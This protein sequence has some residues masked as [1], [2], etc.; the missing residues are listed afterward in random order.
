MKPHHKPDRSAGGC[1]A[2]N[3]IFFLA[4]FEYVGMITSS[5]KPDQIWQSCPITRVKMKIKE[6]LILEI[7]L[8]GKTIEKNTPVVS[9]QLLLSC[10]ESL[11]TFSFVMFSSIRGR[12]S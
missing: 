1:V 4:N 6:W 11:Q 10:S 3:G 12:I 7:K 2:G 9:Y 5:C 8:M